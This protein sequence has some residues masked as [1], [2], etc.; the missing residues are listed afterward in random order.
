MFAER[1]FALSSRDAKISDLVEGSMNDM[2]GESKNIAWRDS[3]FQMF[4]G[5]LRGTITAA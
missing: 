5:D 1:H 4:A 2:T 3:I